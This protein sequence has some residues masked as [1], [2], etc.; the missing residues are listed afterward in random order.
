MRFY[1]VIDLPKSRVDHGGPTTRSA[2]L[3]TFI[4]AMLDC[5]RLYVSDIRVECACTAN[6]RMDPT[7]HYDAKSCKQHAARHGA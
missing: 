2:T 6:S 1:N 5:T 7:E 3:G 4:T